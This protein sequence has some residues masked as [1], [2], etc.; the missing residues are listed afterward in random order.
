MQHTQANNQND[1]FLQFLAANV[2]QD[3]IIRTYNLPILQLVYNW[4]TIQLQSNW[5]TVG[6]DPTSNQD[7]EQE[8]EPMT[9]I[10]DAQAT[11]VPHILYVTCL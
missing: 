1:T 11:Q 6:I 3:T 9:A 10:Q 7:M 8:E 5:S 4:H 2:Q